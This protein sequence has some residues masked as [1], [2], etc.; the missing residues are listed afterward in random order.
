MRKVVCMVL[1][2]ACL[3]AM[4]TGCGGQ[5]TVQGVQKATKA[6]AE[7]ISDEVREQL[8]DTALTKSLTKDGKSVSEKLLDGAMHHPVKNVGSLGVPT[9]KDGDSLSYLERAKV[10]FMKLENADKNSLYSP[11][12]LEMALGL[13]SEG[14]D[15]ATREQ[16]MTFL[17]TEDYSQVA[18][19][20]MEYAD[21]I[22]TTK[23]KVESADDDQMLDSLYGGYNTALQ[24]ANSLWVGGRYS[25][26]DTYL[27]VANDCYDAESAS[28]DFTD[29]I[30]ACEII[31]SWCE[32]KTN[33]LI[34]NMLKPD[35]IDPMLALIL[36]NSVY[37]ESAWTEPWNVREGE[38]TNG[39]GRVVKLGDMLY[40]TED[41]YYETENAVAFGK[42]YISGATFIG[43]LPDEGKSL[44]DID[45]DALLASKTYEYDVHASMPKLNY[46][47][48]CEDLIP[49]LTD[50]RVVDAFTPNALLTKLVNESDDLCVS[51]VLQ[52]CKIE[53]DE[54][55]TKAAA[56]TVMMVKDNAVMLDEPARVKEVHLNRPFYY[57]IVDETL[58]Q[59]LF[60]GAVNVI[61]G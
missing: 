7:A 54:N 55:G 10:M 1:C 13:L 11:L 14:A 15:G 22:T 40:H 9:V 38:F 61:D 43:I 52:K 30:K 34:K 26:Q 44:V 18:K 24:I 16:I 41:A 33:G 6:G 28:V 12:S 3:L 27:G 20:I 21:S 35:S 57:M 2:L 29:A 60:I 5:S 59:V 51:E 56:V 42:K 19:S 53:L 37:F 45:L 8:K 39:D 32:E 49:I 17:G 58:N 4:L 31:N 50:L 47:F 36:C 25:L 48:S 23:E 46:D